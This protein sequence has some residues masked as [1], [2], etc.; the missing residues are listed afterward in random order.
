LKAAPPLIVE[1]A[2]IEQFVQSLREV[3]ETVHASSAFW[4]QALALGRRALNL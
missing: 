4:T 3:M 1:E 2:E